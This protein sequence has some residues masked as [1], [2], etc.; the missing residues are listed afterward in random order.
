MKP[1]FYE[2]ERYIDLLYV[3]GIRGIVFVDEQGCT[4]SE[5]YDEFDSIENNMA[6]HIIG[7][8]SDN[9]IAAGRIVYN[10]NKV[11]KL[12]RI[13]VL[14]KYRR[15]CVGSKLVKYMV[16]VALNKQSTSIYIHAQEHLIPYYQNLGFITSGE[17]FQEARISHIMM[18]YRNSLKVA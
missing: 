17:V 5:E 16:N 8:V 10:K 11:A 7:K 14:K 15:I 9:P 12:E 18:I 1:L 13:S 2:V 6:T 4:F 3:I